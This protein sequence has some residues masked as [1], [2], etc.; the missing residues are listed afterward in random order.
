M[1]HLFKRLT[2]LLVC[3]CL[4]VPCLAGA[5]GVH[6]VRFTMEAEVNPD[7]YPEEDR[8][9]MTALAGLI[10]MISLEGTFEYNDENSIDLNVQMLLEQAEE[11]R[12][13]FR[14]Y[15]CENT[16]ALQSSLLGDQQL[17]FPLTSLLEFCMK[18]YFHLN[19][20]LQRVGLLLTPYVHKDAF[21]TFTS[22][23]DSV[24]NARTGSRTIAREDVLDL[25]A[26]ISEA[27]WT[28]RAF[29]YWVMAVALE[30][31]YDT[32]ITDA[33]TGMRAWADSF[34]DEDGVTVTVA[35]EDQ[36]W[37]TGGTTLFSRTVRDG[38]TTLSLSLPASPDG[39]V[40]SGFLTMRNT[41]AILNADARLTVTLEGESILD[42][43]FSADDL[44]M[45]I[46]A[47]GPF[48]FTWDATGAAVPEGFRLRFEG[49]SVDG[50]FTVRQLDAATG[51]TMLTLRGIAA[52]GQNVS[53][54]NWTAK[55]LN[56]L[57]FFSV[58]DT[59]L[60]QFAA[61]VLPTFAKGVLPLLAHAPVKACQT[62]MDLVTGTGILD[63][64]TSST[65]RLDS[66]DEESY[67]GE[68]DWLDEEGFYGEEGFFDEEGWGDEAGF[69][70][71]EG[72]GIDWDNPSLYE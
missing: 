24:M 25:A 11:T 37:S 19:V 56:G 29:T 71:E 30:S 2:A 1:T 5:E 47:A 13:T 42:L 59:T 12:T 68:A 46:P 49:T 4:L 65:T 61:D 54:L 3:L 48:A 52:P 66:V 17:F 50:A 44:P 27:A 70:D 32:A 7:A 31:G 55:D 36:T 34:L 21:A 22:L 40:L 45:V 23:W 8:A 14:L 28:D 39:Y 51:E 62:L 41:G 69:F 67:I 58:S 43:R 16:W 9:L 64:M 35:G 53:P 6:A 18:A 38:W 26:R 63:L 60:S 15:G 10:D 20:P 72:E 33:F 57:A